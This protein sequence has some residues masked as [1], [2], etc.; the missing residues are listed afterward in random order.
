MPF[1]PLRLTDD[2]RL[3]RLDSLLLAWDY[4]EHLEEVFEAA[5]RRFQRTGAST[6]G[7]ITADPDHADRGMW[8][9]LQKTR[10]PGRAPNRP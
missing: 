9:P 10:A 6:L 3:P 4:Q 5:I 8:A 1:W 2:G 7:S